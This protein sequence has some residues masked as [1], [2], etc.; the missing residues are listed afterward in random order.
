MP[1]L[2]FAWTAGKCEGQM[3]NGLAPCA[4]LLST[5]QLSQFTSSLCFVTPVGFPV[6][7]DTDQT[8]TVIS[9]CGGLN[10]NGPQRLTD[11]NAWSLGSGTIMRW[12]L[13]GGSVSLGYGVLFYFYMIFYYLIFYFH[14]NPSSHSLPLSYTT[15]PRSHLTFTPRKG[16]SFPWGVNTAWHTKLRQYQALLPW[17]K[18]E[19]SILT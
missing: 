17:V 7:P 15:S 8:R 4:V 2:T 3:T 12:I 11:V 19:K 16:Q 6:T 1:L 14:S 10:R 13:V 5:L 18:A 9:P